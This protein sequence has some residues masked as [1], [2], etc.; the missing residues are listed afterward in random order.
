MELPSIPVKP[1]F[2]ILIPMIM[3][4][5]VGVF[6]NNLTSDGWSTTPDSST[7]TS[8]NCPAYL[9][10]GCNAAISNCNI[11]AKTTFSFMNPNSPFTLLLQGNI[12]GFFSNVF[13]SGETPNQIYS[14]YTICIPQIK[15]VYANETGSD[16]SRFQCLGYTASGVGTH[17]FPQVG[18]PM[19]AT[20]NNG[21]NSIWTIQGCQLS[22]SYTYPCTLNYGNGIESFNGTQNQ[23]DFYAFYVP[24]STS[25]MSASGCTIYGSVQA[26]GVLMPWLFHVSTTFTCPNTAHVNGLNIN[27]T[28]YYC[29]LPVNNPVT[30]TNSLPNSFAGLSFIFGVILLFAGFGLA[31]TAATIGFTINEQGTRLAQVFGVGIVI[32]SFVYGEFGASWLTAATLGLGIAAIATSCLT[33]MFFMGMYWQMMSYE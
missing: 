19:N 2:L 18:I 3:L 26:C 21:N 12:I 30:S 16:I 22:Q 4:I 5:G 31:I 1:I 7:C 9:P 10:P 13:T 27:A 24:N 33:V 25:L 29:L 14:G 11:T 8:L 23:M 20:S 15:G 32:W 28:H 17:P 6:V